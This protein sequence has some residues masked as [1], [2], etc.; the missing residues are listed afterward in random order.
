MRTGWARSALLSIVLGL[1]ATS[2]ASAQDVDA[3][4]KLEEANGLLEGLQYERAR[5]GFFEV[6][7]SGSADPEQLA[8]AYFNLGVVEAALNNGTSATDAFYLALMLQ[9]SQALG[10][11]GSPKIE[12]F[13][14]QARD[15]LIAVGA[16]SIHAEVRGGTLRVG[17]ANDP[18]GMVKRLEVSMGES[19]GAASRADVDLGKGATLEVASDVEAVTVTAFDE[20]GNQ[21]RV[22]ELDPS[23]EAEDA[24][25]S[26]G[27]TSVWSR[28]ELW[29][30]LAAASAG[31][32]AYFFMKSGERGDEATAERNRETPD[33]VAISRLEDEESRLGNYGLVGF[34]L[35]GAAAAAAGMILWFD[36]SESGQEE[37][38]AVLP[39][40][41]PGQVGAQFSMR[42]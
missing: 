6:V 12:G 33:A 39:A 8:T 29:A 1:S 34:G 15:R 7:L 2:A 23:E 4:E 30:G 37:D 26:G 3:G 27:G 5:E 17:V 31:G 25:A 35:A 20:S 21:L 40:V 24:A 9:P 42:F 10:L 19:E 41:G 28:W 16:L 18:V 11:G 22:V 14:N 32:G 36:G 38:V 13:L